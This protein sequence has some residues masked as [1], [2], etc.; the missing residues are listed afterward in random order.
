M[1]HKVKKITAIAPQ[2]CCGA[3]RP[4]KRTSMK[5]DLRKSGTCIEY[6]VRIGSLQLATTASRGERVDDTFLIQRAG[7]QQNRVQI[8]PATELLAALA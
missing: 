1:R 5:P 3:S 7:S 6:S 8:E 2:S 4:G